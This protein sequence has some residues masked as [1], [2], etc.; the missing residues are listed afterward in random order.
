MPQPKADSDFLFLQQHFPE[1][2]DLA[3]SAEAH[4]H[5]EPVVALF[6]LR[7]FA[8]V[9]TGKLFDI[10]RLEAAGAGDLHRRLLALREEDILPG[11]TI[12]L[13]FKIKNLGDPF[14]LRIE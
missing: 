3:Q 1:L 12:N 4:L 7:Q 13:L 10:H 5:D 8:E 11:Q 6:K 14:A 2:A 9:L